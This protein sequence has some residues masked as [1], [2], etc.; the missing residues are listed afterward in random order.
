MRIVL[1]GGHGHIAL[2]L[3][4]RTAVAGH[5][6][7]GLIRNAD[8]EADVVAVV[9]ACLENPS[10]IGRQFEVISGDSAIVEALVTL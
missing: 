1:A 5:R 2:L 4:R 7:V 6:A 10:T 8:H 3:S 9:L